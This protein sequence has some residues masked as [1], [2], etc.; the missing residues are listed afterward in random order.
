MPMSEHDSNGR[1]AVS[2][3]ESVPPRTTGVVEYLESTI[4]IAPRRHK[5]SGAF[6]VR[7]ALVSALLVS[8]LLTPTAAP[9]IDRVD[10]VTAKS[11]GVPSS[12]LPEVSMKAGMLV[13]EDGRVL[14]AR[15]ENDKRAMAST[16]KIMTAIVAMENSDLESLVTVP[17]SARLVG[18]A[19][20]FLTAG[21]TLPLSELLEALLVKSGNDASIAIAEHIAGDEKRF[22][23]MMNDKAAEL[24]LSDTHFVNTHGLD[25]KGHYSTAS[26]LAVLGRYAMRKEVFRRIVGQEKA[27]ID[28]SGDSEDVENTNLLLG[29]YEGANG[30][31]TGM[32]NSAG[33]CIVASARRGGV[34]LYAVVLGAKG[35]NSRLNDSRELLDW[36]F[37]HYREQRFASKGSTLGEA[38]VSDYLDVTVP[39]AVS[40][41]TTVAVFDLAGE[42]DRAVQVSELKAP[43]KMGETVG[44][45][46]F[47]QGGRVIA[48]VP[49]VATVDVARPN[50]LQRLGIAFIRVWKRL[51]AGKAEQA[52][53][54]LARVS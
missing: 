45:A 4:G 19:S 44:V 13:T 29:R 27:T 9:A 1:S 33:Y 49:L 23:A 30:V 42:I 31:K 12:A 39:A 18:Y 26:D 28:L 8:T 5:S 10:G 16:T 2:R 53:V 25:A 7:L 50:V 20:P 24:G 14:W 36:G 32:T 38:V 54:G 51:T 35:E 40:V 11:L 22:V 15:R 52:A 17:A 48:T 43:V 37:A 21:K 6:L 41:D 46:T 47:T 34:E 3:E